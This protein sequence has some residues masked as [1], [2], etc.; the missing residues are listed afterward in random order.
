MASLS[1]S[2]F[3]ANRYAFLV[4]QQESDHLIPLMLGTTILAMIS[5]SLGP[6]L[7]QYE[8]L[9][10]TPHKSTTSTTPPP[11]PYMEKVV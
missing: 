11:S 3:W 2:K 5:L 4:S 9:L 1:L 7:F 8:S 10:I 6:C